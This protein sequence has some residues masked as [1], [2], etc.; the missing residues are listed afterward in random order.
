MAEQAVGLIGEVADQFGG[1][2]PSGEFEIEEPQAAAGPAQGVVETEVRG[3]KAAFVP[4]QRGFA[5]RAE[6]LG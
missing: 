6:R 1:I 5:F 4:G 3:R 2:V